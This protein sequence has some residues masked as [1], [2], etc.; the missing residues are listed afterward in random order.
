MASG[1]FP[2]GVVMEPWIALGEK[3]GC[4]AVCEDHYIAAENATD[5]LAPERMGNTSDYA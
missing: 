2:A 4:T 3:L 1:I 5:N